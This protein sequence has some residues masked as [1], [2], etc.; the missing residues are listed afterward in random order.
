MLVDVDEV[1]AAPTARAAIFQKHI[2][3]AVQH[4]ADLS[5]ASPMMMVHR[6]RARQ[7]LRTRTDDLDV[8]RTSCAV[9]IIS[10]PRCS[11]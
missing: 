9:G 8:D 1:D 4:G 3:A 7:Q 5:S 2:S 10:E 6:K 11:K